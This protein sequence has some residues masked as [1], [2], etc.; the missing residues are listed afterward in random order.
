MRTK[1]LSRTTML[2]LLAGICLFGAANPMAAGNQQTLSELCKKLM[3]KNCTPER[4]QQLKEYLGDADISALEK[5]LGNYAGRVPA[6]EALPKDKNGFVD[7]GA[8]VAR[9][10]IQPRGSIAGKE[11]ERYEKYNENLMVMKTKIDVIPD[12]IFPHGV[13][14]YWLSCDSCHPEPFAKKRGKTQFSMGDI[15]DGKY[16]GKCHGTVAFAAQSFK[17]CSR[18]HA[19][20]KTPGTPPWGSF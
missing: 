20:Q 5:R 1:N 12:V 6:F 17:N 4:D 14:T 18:C 7:W 2:I 3:Y 19:L 15:I 9:G 13:H 16:C 10:I 11:N 8:A